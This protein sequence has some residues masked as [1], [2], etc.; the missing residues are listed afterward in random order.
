MLAG[1][2]AT[3]ATAGPAAAA[4]PE[5]GKELVAQWCDEC[6]AADSARSA[7]DVAPPFVRFATDPAYTDERLRGWLHDPHPP[8]PKF[9][10]DRRTID[11]IVAYIRTLKK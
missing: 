3:L 6:H 9:E 1:I 7:S 5:H 2:L 10:L 4:D 8:M 11:D